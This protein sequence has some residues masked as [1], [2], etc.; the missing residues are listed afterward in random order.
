MD[1][2]PKRSRI[3][4]LEVNPLR[5]QYPH[6]LNTY[7]VPPKGDLLFVDFQNYAIERQK[8]LQLLEATI[9]QHHKTPDDL[10]TAFINALKKEEFFTYAKLVN[11]SGC[12]NHNDADLE[13]RKKDHI[14]HFILRLAYC[15]KD[16]LQ[17]YFMN[18]EVEL[19]K[20]RFNS[21]NKEGVNQF[22]VHSG[23]N[24]AQV[25][26]EFKEANR[27]N[28]S[29]S[30]ITAKDVDFINLDFY[31]LPFYEIFDLVS[32]RKV[33]VHK[34]IAYVP[35]TELQSVFVSH[36]RHYL[37]VEMNR[38]KKYILNQFN[39]ER[40][41]AFL[42]SLPDC[43]SE[44]AK[45]IWTT[46][47]TPISKLNEL[48]KTSY[49]L[50]MRIMHDHL[51][52][53]H[54]LKNTARLQY[55]LF[56]KGINVSL[57]DSIE[58][59]K[60]EMTKREGMT[61][62]K[63]NKEYLYHIRYNYGKAG[64]RVDYRPHACPKLINDPIQ[65]GEVHGCPFKHMDTEHLTKKLNECK[66]S[67]ADI[68]IINELASDQHYNLACTKFFESVHKQPPGKMFLHPNGY[69]IQSREILTKDENKQSVEN[70]QQTLSPEKISQPIRVKV[71]N[72]LNTNNV[73]P[74]RTSEKKVKTAVDRKME[75][76]TPINIEAL[77]YDSD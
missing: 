13:A 46:E 1:F 69:Y 49:P 61:E 19:F 29:I 36:F 34:G 75:K 40:I 16:N 5:E 14:A 71:E 68:T 72:N 41:Q 26:Q 3:A 10:K 9:A 8:V 57:D 24:Y 20:M 59:W 62:E 25:S 7:Q 6:D 73:T 15:L 58:F 56:L 64:R 27:D 63:F 60:T 43:F 45:V 11:A 54:H 65:A 23:F 30:T 47:Y 22:L 33:Y 39:D 50:C 67:P 70:T 38:A 52:A 32:D 48:S 77:L 44:M 76:M 21:L 53:N 35:Q 31:E 28:L 4:K 37:Q 12:A 55:G 17:Q 51:I 66:I 74:S 42:R 2:T 18:L